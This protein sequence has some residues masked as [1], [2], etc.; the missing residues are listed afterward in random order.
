MSLLEELQNHR[1]EAI[2]PELGSL[3]NADALGQWAWVLAYTA[4]LSSVSVLRYHLWIANGLDLGQFEQGLWLIWHQGIMAPST[5]TGLPILADGG[6]FVLM[7]LSPLYALGGTGLL[8]VLQAFALGTGYIFVRGLGQATGANARIA[9]LLGLAYLIYPTVLGTN[10]FDFHPE[11]LGVPILF[12]LIWA[13]ISKRWIPFALFAA[14]TLTINATAP[15]LL[16]GTALVLLLRK[17][18]LPALITAAVAA[19]AGLL[20]VVSLLPALGS[21]AVPFW[22]NFYSNL[23]PT[24]SAGV[25]SLLAHPSLLVG[26]I[27]QTRPWEYIAW[28]AA[29]PAACLILARRLRFSLWW[30]PALILMEANLLSSQAIRTSPFNEFSLL[31]VPFVFGGLVEALASAWAQPL[32]RGAAYLAVPLILLGVFVWQQQKT[33]WHSIPPNATA[34]QSAEAVVPKEA[35]LVVQNLDAAHFANRPDEWLPGSAVRQTLRPGTYVVLDLTA[36]TGTTPRGV[37]T[38]LELA[39]AGKDQ[40]K[41]VF[42]EN[43]VQVYKL[44][45]PLRPAART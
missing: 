13:G 28:I 26:W 17:Q 2:E 10:L 24:P 40:A 42:S 7:F 36:S 37:L 30:I 21:G 34:L 15:L 9:H 1:T 20:E 45:R 12:A 29:V 44:L 18:A 32:K 23:G 31:A 6:A 35:P 8:L 11:V 14:L 38:S 39:L 5:Y 27:S 19:A 25:G 43:G 16:L 3:L 4:V 41:L 22:S 33:Y